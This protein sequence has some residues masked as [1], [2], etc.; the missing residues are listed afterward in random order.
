MS[1]SVGAFFF[2]LQR[3]RGVA[4]NNQNVSQFAKNTQ[5]LRVVNSLCKSSDKGNCRRGSVEEHNTTDQAR[6][7]AKAKTNYIWQK[8]Y[9][10]VHT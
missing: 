9:I 8:R 1:R 4:H 7:F 2:W 10:N 6:P 3:Q 5:A